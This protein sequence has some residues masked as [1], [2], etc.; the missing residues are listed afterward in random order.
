MAG[1]S[2][3][4]YQFTDHFGKDANGNERVIKADPVTGYQFKGGVNY[5][6]TSELNVFTNLGYVAKVPIFDNVIDD[7][8]GRLVNDPK[9]EKFTSYEAGVVYTSPDKELKLQSNVYYTL[10]KDQAQTKDVQNADT[11]WGQVFLNGLNS[12]YYGAEFEAAWQPS[13]Y[14]KIDGAASFGNWMYTD[15][16]SGAYRPNPTTETYYTYY[17]K[18]LKIGD[19]PQTQFALAG[20]VYPV[21]RL[22]L[23]L[24]WKHYSDYYSSWDPFSRTALENGARPQSW[25]IPDYS[26]F[27]LHV[28]YRLPLETKKTEVKLFAHVFNLFD[29]VYV[30]DAVDN[31]S[32][33]KFDGNHSADDAAVFLGLPR[34]WNAGV[35]VNF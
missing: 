29:K 11:T 4:K 15:D 27:D 19:A 3:I 10:W 24:V 31:A 23:Q 34:S 12:R 8:T 30:Q 32:Y 7:V 25:K 9:N 28:S 35:E 21:S 18:G 1:W 2:T 17:I 20:T 26:L 5:N 33:A 6:L 16:V 13:K 22:S 14:F